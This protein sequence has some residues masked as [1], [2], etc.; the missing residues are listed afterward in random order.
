M[1][2]TEAT[3][4]AAR[5]ARAAP[6]LGRF[7]STSAAAALLLPYHT[8]H[9]T[10]TAVALQSNRPTSQSVIS[11]LKDYGHTMAKSLIL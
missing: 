4:S 2:C 7:A 8:I 11:L 6:C 3:A 5:A 10:T 9:Y 1:Q